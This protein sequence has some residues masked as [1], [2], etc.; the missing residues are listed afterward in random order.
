MTWNLNEVETSN[1]KNNNKKDYKKVEW[2]KTPGSY[3]MTINSMST[4][5]DNPNWQGGTPYIEFAM[6]TGDGRKITARFYQPKETDKPSSADFKRKLLKEFL[7]NA[8][9]TEFDNID[10]SMTQAIG[11]RLQCVFCT[12]EYVGTDRE[13]NEPVV[14]TALKYKFSKKMG[15]T[16]KYDAKYNKS[17]SPDQ[18][19][20]FQEL[21][22]IWLDSN[23]T[24]EDDVVFDDRDGV[25]T[26]RD[27][28]NLPF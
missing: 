10:D 3:T 15:Q 2:L 27:A 4:Q 18:H 19:K 12:E 16:I 5:D 7:V 6:Y 14:R 23:K 1:N 20:D 28:D 17:L 8:G 13:T 21:H 9:V 25:P 24:T 11:K 26:M 22:R